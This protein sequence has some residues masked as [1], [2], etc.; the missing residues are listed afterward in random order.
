LENGS[1][2]DEGTGKVGVTVD[3]LNDGGGGNL[4]RRKNPKTEVTAFDDRFW[5]N[6]EG[7]EE[8]LSALI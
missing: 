2:V 7:Q 8:S 1:V 6:F 3:G 5:L 4:V